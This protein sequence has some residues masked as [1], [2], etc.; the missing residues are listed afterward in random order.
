MHG[1]AECGARRP[2]SCV[3]AELFLN[4]FSVLPW[5]H[6]RDPARHAL[7]WSD[8][9]RDATD[10]SHYRVWLVDAQGDGILGLPF[11]HVPVGAAIAINDVLADSGAS[12]VDVM[13]AWGAF[14]CEEDTFTIWA[15]VYRDGG[16]EV[17][18][19]LPSGELRP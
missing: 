1:R 9:A 19:V 13:E 10:F 11:L 7:T 18:Y 16:R 14:A 5:E 8:N 15:A 4:F 3:R 6:R 17:E 12:E 2:A